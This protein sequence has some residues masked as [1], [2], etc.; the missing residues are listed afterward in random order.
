MADSESI[1][2]IVKQVVM[3]AATVVMIAFRDKEMGPQSATTPNQWKSEAKKW[4]AGT[5]KAKI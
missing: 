2:E 1:K 4:R 5:T 3:Q